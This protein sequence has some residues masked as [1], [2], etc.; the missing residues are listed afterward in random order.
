M[1]KSIIFAVFLTTLFLQP[2]AQ[3]IKY[4][5]T[6]KEYIDRCYDWDIYQANIC[7]FPAELEYLCDDCRY[8]GEGRTQKNGNIIPDGSG[9]YSNIIIESFIPPNPNPSSE[10]DFDLQIFNTETQCLGDSNCNR[11]V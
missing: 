6:E 5:V 11:Y 3:A 4:K 7:P 1:F 10:D 2:S 8:D 9:N